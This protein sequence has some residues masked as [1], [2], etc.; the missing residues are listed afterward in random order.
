MK[1]TFMGIDR[2]GKGIPGRRLGKQRPRRMKQHG[3]F[4]SD[5]CF[6]LTRREEAGEVSRGHILGDSVS[7]FKARGIH[8]EGV[9]RRAM[10][11]L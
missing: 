7:L 5:K 11:M 2:F 9:Q 3:I 10:E 6:R 8:L 4:Q 1:D